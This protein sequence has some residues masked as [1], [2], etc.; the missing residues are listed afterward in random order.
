MLSENF[1]TSPS[2][3]RPGFLFR[4][5]PCPPL[6]FVFPPVSPSPNKAPY[7]KGQ[8]RIY[9]G[10]RG[11]VSFP[12]GATGPE[13]RERGGPVFSPPAL[14]K[15]PSPGVNLLVF[16]PLY[17]RTYVICTGSGSL[18]SSCA[19]KL[20]ISGR[21]KKGGWMNY[22]VKLSLNFKPQ[23]PRESPPRTRKAFRHRIAKRGWEK[24]RRGIKGAA[25]LRRNEAEERSREPGTAG[26]FYDEGPARRAAPSLVS[27]PTGRPRR[28]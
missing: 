10:D 3:C 25:V 23:G 11:V 21:H 13:D 8:G 27:V 26:L 6:N 2:P 9:P 16:I 17:T 4:R 19:G 5:S 12:P 22:E 1:Q 18:R 15:T 20:Q 24:K 14:T 28:R 7:I